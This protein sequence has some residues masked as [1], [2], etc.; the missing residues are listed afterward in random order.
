MTKETLV[1][2]S[3]ELETCGN[4]LLQ[5]A[6]ALRTEKK[7]LASEPP[8]KEPAPRTLTLEEVRKVR[9][10]SPGRGSRKKFGT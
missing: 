10:T 7:A 1:K 3:V 6:E 4:A 9:R 8:K 2:L 5:I